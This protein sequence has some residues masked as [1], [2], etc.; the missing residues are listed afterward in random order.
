MPTTSSAS[1][2]APTDSG[3]AVCRVPPR[4]EQLVRVLAGTVSLVGLGLG[5]FVSPWG[6]LLTVFAGLNVIQ[7][8]FTGF[9][10]PEMLYRWLKR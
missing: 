5:F 4:Q 9:C 3:P 1:T 8:A 2:D 7:S 10:P 6:Y